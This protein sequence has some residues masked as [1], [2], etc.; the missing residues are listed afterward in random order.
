MKQTTEKSITLEE[1]LLSEKFAKTKV[2]GFANARR[3]FRFLLD[4]IVLQ[5]GYDGLTMVKTVLILG[6]CYKAGATSPCAEADVSFEFHARQLNG[7]WHLW[8]VEAV[9]VDHI[10]K[11]TTVKAIEAALRQVKCY[12]HSYGVVHAIGDNARWAVK[13]LDKLNAKFF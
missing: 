6:R 7:G 3:Q 9:S 2:S 11:M 8:T 4:K 12:R 13:S 1:S 5:P 10:L